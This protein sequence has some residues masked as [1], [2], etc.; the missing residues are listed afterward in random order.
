MTIHQ[1]KPRGISSW[2]FF[3]NFT[4]SYK[5]DDARYFVLG[6]TARAGVCDDVGVGFLWQRSAVVSAI[7]LEVL[8]VGAED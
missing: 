6:D 2:L 5:G 4:S 8:V 1:K 3:N 7:P